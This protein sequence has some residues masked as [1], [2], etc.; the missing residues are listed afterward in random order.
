M[1]AKRYFKTY[2]Q[3]PKSLLT[4]YL[5]VNPGV[6]ES[7]IRHYLYIRTGVT[8][9]FVVRSTAETRRLGDWR[10]G[11]DKAGRYMVATGL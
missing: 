2:L 9:S 11:G 1:F 6:P 10:M 5:L 7:M 8:W 3:V 4:F